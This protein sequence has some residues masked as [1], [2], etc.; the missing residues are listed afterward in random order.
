MT[1][2]RTP[3][4]KL[5]WNTIGEPLYYCEEC[6]KYVSVKDDNGVVTIK[7]HCDHNDA[8]IL[9]PRKSFLSGTGYAG[10]TI[11]NKVKATFGQVASKLTGRNV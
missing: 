4:E 5:L 11:P 10:L 6:L 7:R 8:R 1:D 2:A 9:A 3:V